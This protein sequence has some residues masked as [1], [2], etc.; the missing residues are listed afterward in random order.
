M[1]A[2]Q[3]AAKLYEARDAAQTI[4]GKHYAERVAAATKAANEKAQRDKTTHT[5]AAITLAKEAPNTIIQLLF[6]ASIVETE[7][8]STDSRAIV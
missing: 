7:E 3:M 5:T 2:I 4:L 6:L 1:N 8:P